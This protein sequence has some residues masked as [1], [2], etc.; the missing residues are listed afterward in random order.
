[1]TVF[2]FCS[3]GDVPTSARRAGLFTGNNATV[4]DSRDAT[5]ADIRDC[6]VTDSKNAIAVGSEDGADTDSRD[7]RDTD[8]KTTTPAALSHAV[9]NGRT[10]S[11]DFSVRTLN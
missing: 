2:L 6:S 8:S 11:K 4:A 1:M 9:T 10:R 7:N 5:A 3:S